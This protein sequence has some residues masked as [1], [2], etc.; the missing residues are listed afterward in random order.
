[1]SAGALG[2]MDAQRLEI[3]K[4]LGSWVKVLS[5]KCSWHVLLQADTKI[6]V[7]F[8]E[9]HKARSK[10]TSAIVALKK[11]LMHN[12]KDGVSYYVVVFSYN[13]L[14]ISSSQL[15]RFAKSSSLRCCAILTSCG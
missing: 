1:M 4:Y 3:M 7:L 5:G 10:K 2:S 13:L 15:P 14:T 6:C 12:E 9:V 8:S 11:I